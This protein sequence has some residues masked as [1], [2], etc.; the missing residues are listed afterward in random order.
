MT[1][2]K[3]VKIKKLLVCCVIAIALSAN[4][5]NSAVAARYN[6][7]WYGTA[8]YSV[9]GEFNY[10]ENMTSEMILETGKGQTQ[11]LQ[12][13][14][15]SFYNP[16]GEL[17]HTYNNVVDRQATGNYFEFN[18]DPQTQQ[19][20]GNLDLGGETVGD[21]Y[22]KGKINKKLSLIEVQSGDREREVDAFYTFSP[23]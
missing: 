12:S 2:S 1:I 18:F 8:G 6:F 17:I 10:D 22:L 19:P 11:Q 3:I 13:L 16:K 9:K 23:N 7:Q 5:A 4:L 20:I 15:V 14:T 21:M